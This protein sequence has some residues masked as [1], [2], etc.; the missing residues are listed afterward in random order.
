MLID[1]RKQESLSGVFEEK[2]QVILI[3]ER[4]SVLQPRNSDIHPKLG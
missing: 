2:V 4:V 1:I 3:K